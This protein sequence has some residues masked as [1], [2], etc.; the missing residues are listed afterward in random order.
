MPA[1]T[2]RDLASIEIWNQS[3]VRSQR[4]RELAAAARKDISRKKSA[5]LAISAAM[6]ASPVWPSVAGSVDLST[7]EADRLAKKN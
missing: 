2:N 3:L 7:T 1:I 4:R 6:A 5:S